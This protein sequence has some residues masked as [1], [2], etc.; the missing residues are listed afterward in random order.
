MLS[1]LRARLRALL[2]KSARSWRNL[3]SFIGAA[4]RI[5]VVASLGLLLFLLPACAIRSTSSGSP[6]ILLFNGNGT[7]SNDVAAIEKLLSKGDFGYTTANSRQLNEMSESRLRAYRLLIVPGGN[8]EQIG[9]GLTSRAT[10]NIRNAVCSGLNYLG[11]CA[12]AFFAGETPYNGLNLTSGVKFTFYALENQG[13]RKAAVEIATAGSP[14]L[15]HYWEDGP[16][17]TGWGDVVA[18][19]PDGT[20]AIVEGNVGDGWVI[21]SGIHPEAPESW[22]RGLTFNTTAGVDNAYAATL[23]SAAMNRIRLEHY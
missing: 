23:I 21:L 14:S 18:R 22:R 15:T 7:S 2:R 5:L 16:Q 11:I 17:L 19:Y 20:P 10:A 4:R 1:K 12:G 13:V 8:F 3:L 6:T 9:N